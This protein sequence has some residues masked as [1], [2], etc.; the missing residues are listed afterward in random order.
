MSQ[1]RMKMKEGNLVLSILTGTTK[2]ILVIL[3]AYGSISSATS[4]N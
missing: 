3:R 4:A 1:R 2:D